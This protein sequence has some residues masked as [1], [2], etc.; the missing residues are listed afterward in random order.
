[1]CF[2]KY[3]TLNDLAN[4][5][6]WWFKSSYRC[7]PSIWQLSLVCIRV[8]PE[9]TTDTKPTLVITLAFPCT[10]WRRLSTS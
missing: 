6:D 2:L 8:W 10:E 1:M 4:F 9:L 3:F 7:C 5:Q